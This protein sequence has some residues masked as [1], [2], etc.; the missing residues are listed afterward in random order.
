MKAVEDSV[1]AAR[2]RPSI[3]N[4]HAPRY[5]LA[6]ALA[7]AA[8]RARP[9]RDNRLRPH[10]PGPGASCRRL[11][12]GL[13]R[14]GHGAGLW[15]VDIRSPTRR[16]VFPQNADKLMMPA[17]NMKILTLAAAAERSAGI[18]VSRPRSRRGAGRG[19]RP[20]RR[21]HRPGQRRPDDQTRE[22]AREA[23]F[24]EW[25]QALRDAG[26][27]AIDGRVLGD[28]QAFVTRGWAGLVMGLSRSRAMRLQSARFIQREMPP[29]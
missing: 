28:D 19:R 1:G 5:G 17:S 20:P 4:A 2:E 18:I 14:S 26:I 21:P 12:I 29:S 27:T 6:A 25:A 23:V 24:D 3:S 9:I 16:V 8:A 15:G 7:S 22:Q 11:G 13:Q 10:N